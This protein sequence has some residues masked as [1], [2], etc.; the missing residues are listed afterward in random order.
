MF[1]WAKHVNS[2]CY[3]S[4]NSSCYHVVICTYIIPRCRVPTSLWFLEKPWYL[5]TDFKCAWKPLKNDVWLKFAQLPLGE[6]TKSES[7]FRFDM[8]VMMLTLIILVFLLNVSSIVV[9]DHCWDI[10][11][12]TGVAWICMTKR[13]LINFCLIFVYKAGSLH[14]EHPFSRDYM[15]LI[16]STYTLLQSNTALSSLKLIWNLPR[17]VMREFFPLPNDM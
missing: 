4:L 16:Y 2:G 5:T 13:R 10:I 7:I 9:C 3:K 1:A 15:C 8:D 17:S 6:K 11:L 14:S 12:A